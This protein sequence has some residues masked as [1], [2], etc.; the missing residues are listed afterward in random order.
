[1][2]LHP[3]GICSAKELREPPVMSSQE[4]RELVLRARERQQ[5]RLRGEGVVANSQMDVGMLRRHVALD[6]SGVQTLRD[7]QAQC[8]LSVRGQHRLL[9]VARTVADLE[10]SRH[11]RG[12]HLA[13]ALGWRPEAALESR[14]M[15]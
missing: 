12:R 1:M 5:A 11:T 8:T 14:R 7:V 3:R 13:E 6:Q 9:R 4:G 2:L 15:A 10:G